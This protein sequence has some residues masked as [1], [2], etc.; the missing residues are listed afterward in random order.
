MTIYIS[1]LAICLSYLLGSFSSAIIFCQLLNLPDPRTK[2][3][4]NPGATN[5]LRMGSKTAAL[6]TLLGDVA[7]GIIPVVIAKYL[8]LDAISIALVAYAAFLGHLYPIFFR[9][10]GGK[11]VA[12]ALGAIIAL[13]PLAALS[14]VSIWVIVILIFRFSSLASIITAIFAP[15][16]I[17]LFTTNIPYTLSVAGMSLLLILRHRINIKKLTAGKEKSLF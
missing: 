14:W 2:G 4:R 11:G 12:T 17:Y 13:S 8:S 6:L 9:F 15:F 3:S 10:E 1:M 16:I 7:K 5:V